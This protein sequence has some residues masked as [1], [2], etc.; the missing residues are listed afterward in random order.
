M[1]KLILLPAMALAMLAACGPGA[2]EKKEIEQ[3]EI[4]AAKEDSVAVSLEQTQQDIEKATQEL[5]NL[6]NEL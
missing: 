4:Q 2:S 1:K 5:E 6:V 3:L